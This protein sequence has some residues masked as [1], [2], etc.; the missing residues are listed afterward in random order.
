MST[1]RSRQRATG[2][3]LSTHSGGKKRKYHHS[4]ICYDNSDIEE[5]TGVVL[6]P[7]YKKTG[8]NRLV[9]MGTKYNING[10]MAHLFFW[11]KAAIPRP[12]KVSKLPQDFDLIDYCHD[13]L[14]STPQRNNVFDFF[15]DRPLER[16]PFK[17][18][19]NHDVQ[20]SEI[21]ETSDLEWENQV[22]T[23]FALDKKSPGCWAIADPFYQHRKLNVGRSLLVRLHDAIPVPAVGVQ[24]LDLVEFKNK[25]AQERKALRL[26]LSKLFLKIQSSSD[27]VLSFKLELDNLK[28]AI[29]DLMNCFENS[30]FPMSLASMEARL[31]WDIDTKVAL[32]SGAVMYSL[33]GLEE[34]LMAAIGTGVLVNLLP[35]IEVSISKGQLPRSKNPLTY[36]H[37]ISDQFLTKV[38]AHPLSSDRFIENGNGPTSVFQ[39]EKWAIEFDDPKFH[40]LGRDGDGCTFFVNSAMVFPSASSA[41][42]YID[43]N[44]T[45]L[46]KLG[47]NPHLKF[48]D[49]HS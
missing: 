13:Q 34:A 16:H 14:L 21:Y 40:L 27:S 39:D 22:Q 17:N 29:S 33:K 36:A 46:S 15:E 18:R 38:E 30:S 8:Q 3:S 20:R 44:R 47:S 37:L 25:C 43:A 49:G 12:N 28:D 24:L 19:R 26:H 7:S 2:R 41:E 9:S 31:H 23:F 48:I 42:E 1:E 5:W 10:V 11:D 32:G 6:P 45:N 35:K 4:I